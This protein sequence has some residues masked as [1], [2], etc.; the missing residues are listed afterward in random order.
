MSGLVEQVKEKI[1]E[2]IESAD[3]V[4]DEAEAYIDKASAIN[5]DHWVNSPR[6]RIP[7]DDQPYGEELARL[8]DSPKALRDL[9]SE[10]ERTVVESSSLAA[11]DETL[12]NAE[13]QIEGVRSTL[14]DIADIPADD[15]DLQS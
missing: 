9:V 14:G 1:E 4:A 11:L 6:D 12:Q 15:D 13:E 2:L 7:L 5:H 8:G 10:L 3:A